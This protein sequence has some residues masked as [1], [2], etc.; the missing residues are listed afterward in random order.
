[1]AMP[2]LIV[3]GLVA[4]VDWLT[5]LG[6]AR[7]FLHGHRTVTHSVVGT[8]VLA[9]AVALLFFL[10]GRKWPKLGVPFLPILGICTIGATVHLLLDL[11]NGDGVMLLWPFSMRW[12]GWDLTATVDAW[13]LFFL[14]TGLLLPA[15]LGLILEEIGSKSK[16]RK[17]QRGAFVSLA[18]VI[19]FVAG[20]AVAH[21]HAIE[22]LNDG[23]YRNESPM[24]V[25][26]FPRGYSPL[27]WSGVVETDNAVG[28]VEVP[29][30]PGSPF[31]P[32][33]AALHFKPNP[34]IALENAWNSPA[35]M[36][37]LAY[38]RFPLADV[39]PLGDGL[40][41]RLRD[42]RYESGLLGQRGIIAVIDLNARNVVVDARLEF[43]S[44]FNP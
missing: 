21:Q 15:L 16:H 35:A 1:M 18:L 44:S 5:R 19:L 30:S 33:L 24:N 6:G 17:G 42:M 4:D 39:E 11:L 36:E 31:Y 13:I 29:L 2:A 43:D 37:F 27:V 20:R 26:A 28:N 12:F 14:L 34:T 10:V 41:V 9:V 23:T 3:S 7:A 8:V 40:E 25:G 32:Q 38:A 22:L